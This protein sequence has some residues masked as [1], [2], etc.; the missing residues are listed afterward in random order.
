MKFT[1]EFE[2]EKLQCS[3]CPFHFTDQEYYDDFCCIKL[4]DQNIKYGT[5]AQVFPEQY[6]P[7]EW[8]PVKNRRR[9]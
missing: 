8:C 2:T 1:Y 4:H 9:I 3:T 5:D 7:P 6:D